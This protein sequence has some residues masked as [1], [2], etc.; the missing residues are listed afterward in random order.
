VR[1]WSADV[2]VD[3]DLVGRLIAGQ[4]PELAR[5]SLRPFAE[6]WD[7]AVWL[8]DERWAFRFPRRTM[9]VAAIERE[10]RVLPR[11][12]PQLP[13]P[14]PVPVFVGRPAAGYPWPFYG[15]ALIEGLEA[16]EAAL[17]D[18][19]RCRLAPALAAFLRSLHDSQVSD[20][21]VD[22]NRR[23]D[24]PYRAAMTIDWL[25]RLPRRMV[26]AEVRRLLVEAERLPAPEGAVVAHGDLHFRHVL[27]GGG[28]ALA[29]VIDWGDVCRGDPSIDLSLL[30][31]FFPAAGRSAFLAAYGMVGEAQLLRA[32]ALALNLCTILA[33]YGREAGMPGVEREAL[34]GLERAV[35]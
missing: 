14:V 4:F 23:A 8:V 29:G 25:G 13:A 12:A 19:A 26:P 34:E 15:S 24:M 1:E 2:T 3:E 16:G 10:L 20:L 27:V 28:G 21:P 33:V 6:G 7:N 18:E 31:S 35:A 9:G 32:R 11:L 17:G 22:P 5:A 30:W